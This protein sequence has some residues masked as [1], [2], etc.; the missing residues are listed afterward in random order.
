MRGLVERLTLWLDRAS[1]GQLDPEDQPLHLP[2]AYPGMTAGVVVVRADIGHLAPPGRPPRQMAGGR[3]RAAA[4]DQPH[5]HR[6]LVAV[7]DRPDVDRLD[8][9]EWIGRQEWLERLTAGRLP[10]G[11]AGR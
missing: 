1:L 8:I 5:D 6:L 7:C 9:V 4:D 2:V 11:R 10:A 3:G